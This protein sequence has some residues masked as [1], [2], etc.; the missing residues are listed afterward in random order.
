MIEQ[1][2]W[3]GKVEIDGKMYESIQDV[4]EDI[5]YG[6]HIIRLYPSEKKEENHVKTVNKGVKRITVKPYMTQKSGPSFDFM[7]KFNEDR[8]MPLLT[9]EGEVL[10]ETRGMVYMKLRGFAEATCTCS[11]CGKV[12][13]NEV[14]RYYGIGP[15]CLAKLGIQANIEDVQHIKEKLE[16]IEWTGWVIKSAIIKEEIL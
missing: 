1:I 8:P 11:V 4:S 9:M 13:K 2:K 10:K 14:S 16:E 5:R 12:L 15:I 3:Q 7:L 6:K